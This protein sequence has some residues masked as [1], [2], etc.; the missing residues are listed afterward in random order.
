MARQGVCRVRRKAAQSTENIEDVF[1]FTAL[2]QGADLC[3]YAAARGF[4]KGSDYWLWGWCARYPLLWILS[5]SSMSPQG[6]ATGVLFPIQNS[7][8]VVWAHP[9]LTTNTA[10]A[11]SARKYDTTAKPV[12]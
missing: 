6:G 4:F 12:C 9:D 3:C 10:A 7:P 11:H 8:W 5:L 1:L 2:E